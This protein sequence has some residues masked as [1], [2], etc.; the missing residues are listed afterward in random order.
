MSTY[1]RDDMRRSGNRTTSGQRR[2]SASRRTDSTRSRRPRDYD[3]DLSFDLTEDD[4]VTHDEYNQRMGRTGSSARATSARVTERKRS[5][6]SLRRSSNHS[7]SGA[8]RDSSGTRRKADSRKDTRLSDTRKRPAKRNSK[9]NKKRKTRKLF[10]V[11]EIVILLILA[12][13]FALWMKFG[14]ANWDSINM[15]DLEV[16][17]LDSETEELLS[18]YTTLALFGVDNRSNGNYSSGN[19]DTIMLVSINNDTKEVKMVSVAR[20]TYLKVSD[21]KYAKANY[22]YNSGGA[23]TAISMLNTNLDLKIDGYVAVDFYALA[24]IVDDLGGLEVEITQAMIDT[25][26]PET[27]QNALAGYIAEVESVLDYYPDKEDGWDINDC[28]FDS[29]G[30]Y[31][32]NG[33]QVVGY[34]RNRYVGNNDFGRAERQRDVVKKIIEKA[35]ASDV[36]TINKIV[37]DVLPSV[38]TSLSASQCLSLALSAADYEISDSSGFP[39]TLT[40]GT[41]GGASIVVPCTLETNVA[42]LHEF[43]YDQTD[44][45]TTDEVDEISDY[46]INYTGCDEDDADVTQTSDDSSDSE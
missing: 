31:T 38:S 16:N 10:I 30:T 17:Q 44:Y 4:L 37:D 22:G 46:I 32:L 45:D 12:L 8:T 34:C 42:E 26:N 15:D 5:E 28:Y 23:E 24:T 13:I 2:T 33:A 41:Y 18:N 19:S 40:T 35:I 21:S 1:N 29:P 39:F 27:N 3:S 9:K 6:N 14:K 36:S 25:D 20:D 43:L 11:V 7:A